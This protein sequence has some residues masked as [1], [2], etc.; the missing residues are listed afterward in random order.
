ML[1]TTGPWSSTQACALT[2]A[3]AISG[4]GSVT[5][6]G[7]GALTLS[8]NIT[9]GGSLTQAGTG[10][11][12]LKGTDTSFTGTI[13]VNPGGTLQIGSAGATGMVGSGAITDNGAWSSI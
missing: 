8:G 7:S 13:A 9:G 5:Q 1:R 6:E 3:N 11:V 12:V 4:S 2:V 10:T